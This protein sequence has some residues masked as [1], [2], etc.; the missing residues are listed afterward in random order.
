MKGMGIIFVK[1]L[2]IIGHNQHGLQL[3]VL[4]KGDSTQYKINHVFQSLLFEIHEHIK[5]NMI[6]TESFDQ[7]FFMKTDC[8]YFIHLLNDK[9]LVI[10]KGSI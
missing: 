3:V 2:W 1:K 5:A 6:S 9:W 4:Q 8:R 10:I 7:T